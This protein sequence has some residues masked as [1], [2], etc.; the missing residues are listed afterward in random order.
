MVRDLFKGSIDRREGKACWDSLYKILIQNS[1]ADLISD[2][3]I[4]WKQEAFVP[5]EKKF[6]VFQPELFFF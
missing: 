1:N 2:S 3:R 6:S 4:G 5:T